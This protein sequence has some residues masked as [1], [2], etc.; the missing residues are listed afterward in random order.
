MAIQA[1]IAFVVVM[2]IIAV[3]AIYGLCSVCMSVAVFSR[4]CG[5]RRPFRRIRPSRGRFRT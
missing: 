2:A 5:W 3:P 1:L 4:R